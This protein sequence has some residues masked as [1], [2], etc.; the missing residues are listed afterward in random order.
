VLYEVG[1][2]QVKGYPS[3]FQ[4]EETNPLLVSLKRRFNAE[5]DSLPIIGSGL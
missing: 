1:G 3:E 5:E 4:C 2:A